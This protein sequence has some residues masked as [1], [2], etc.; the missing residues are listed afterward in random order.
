MECGEEVV[1]ILKT[2]VV[3]DL[4]DRQR[5]VCKGFLDVAHYGLHF[6]ETLLP[7]IEIAK[8]QEVYNYTAQKRLESGFLRCGGGDGGLVSDRWEMR[9]IKFSIRG[10]LFFKQRG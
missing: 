4:L 10:A 1:V 5:T 3:R 9:R 2:K 8:S 6:G 7:V